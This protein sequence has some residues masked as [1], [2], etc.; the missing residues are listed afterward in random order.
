MTHLARRDPA[1]LAQVDQLDALAAQ[2]ADLLLA[3][4]VA[5]AA[6]IPPPISKYVNFVVALVSSLSYSCLI[7]ASRA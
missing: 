1:G 6:P 5:L 4:L 3:D 2:V 7:Y